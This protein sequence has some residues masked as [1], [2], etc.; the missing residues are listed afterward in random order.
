MGM[1][2]VSAYII[3]AM[4][5]APTL[6]ELGVNMI[7]AHFF[8]FYF[9]ILSFVT[10][11]VALAAYAA[12]GIAKGDAFRTGFKAFKFTFSGFVVPFIFVYD[13]SLLLMGEPLHIVV[14]FLLTVFSVWIFSGVFENYY[15]IKPNRF[16][17]V[18]AV[19]AVILLVVPVPIYDYAG[20]ALGCVLVGWLYLQRLS[21]AG[22]RY[23]GKSID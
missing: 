3:V 20:L 21:L 13:Q 10:P 11:P 19:V 4:L 17:I 15:F 8:V 22:R 6:V 18:M 12:A 5:M 1:P 14:R 16:Q 7:A 2:S 9:A 23:H